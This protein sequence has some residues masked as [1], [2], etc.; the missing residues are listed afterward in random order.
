M[1]TELTYFRIFILSALALNGCGSL[2]HKKDDQALAQVKKIAV[3]AFT[4]DEPASASIGFNL[5]SH[6]AGAVAGGSIIPQ[7]SD[8]VKQMLVELQNAFARNMSWSVLAEDAMIKNPGYVSAYHN[9]MDGW[10]SKSPP[11]A[12][13]N[14]FLVEHVM[15]SDSLRILGPEGRDKLITDLGVDAIAVGKVNVVNSGTSI[16]GIGSRHPQANFSFTLYTRGKEDPTWFE[17]QIKGD[18][19]TES[20]GSTHFTDEEA[21]ARL[22]LESAKTAFAKIGAAL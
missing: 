13:L 20:V 10:Q 22:S 17:G 6:Q 11:N 3:V 12:G 21:T 14:R 8:S 18:E 5:N 4:A 1:N 7:H 19:S 2:T 15:D 9:T 16:M